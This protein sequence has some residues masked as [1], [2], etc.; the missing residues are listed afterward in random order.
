MRKP[1]IKVVDY[2]RWKRKFN[3]KGTDCYSFG[4]KWL[5]IDYVE[6]VSSKGSYS[7]ELNME[8]VHYHFCGVNPKTH[9]YKNESLIDAKTGTCTR[10]KSNFQK[11]CMIDIVLEENYKI[12]G[13][14]AK[15]INSW[16][17]LS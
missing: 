12:N 16:I 1:K 6:I 14:T 7:S 5:N 9:V 3:K 13:F 11:L 4:K 15:K 10:I 17:C 2:H 8:Q